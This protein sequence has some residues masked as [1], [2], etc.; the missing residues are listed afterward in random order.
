MTVIPDKWVKN[1][2]RPLITPTDSMKRASRHNAEGETQ[3]DLSNLI[4]LGLTDQ[5]VW[6]LRQLA[7]AGKTPE[8]RRV[9][10]D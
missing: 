6:M 10:R 5:N 9:H 8:E 1:E 3:R 7:I 4:N 2:V